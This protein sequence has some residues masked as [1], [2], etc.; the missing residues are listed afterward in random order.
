MN[1]KVD[2]GN[3]VDYENSNIFII[4]VSV[5]EDRENV[6]GYSIKI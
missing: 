2:L 3:S 5:N 4:G 1:L 6:P